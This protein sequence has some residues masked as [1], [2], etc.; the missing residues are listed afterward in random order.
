MFPLY[1]C[2]CLH[3]V[4]SST[5]T[6]SKLDSFTNGYIHTIITVVQEQDR[7]CNSF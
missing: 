6:S 7:F 1:T 2:I 3:V 5:P 4:V